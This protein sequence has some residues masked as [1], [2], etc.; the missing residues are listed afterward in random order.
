MLRITNINLKEGIRIRLPESWH[1]VLS[2]FCKDK[3]L[4]YEYEIERITR[5]RNDKEICCICK[6]KRQNSRMYKRIVLKEFAVKYLL[7]EELTDSNIGLS[8][9]KYLPAEN[10]K[11]LIT[12]ETNPSKVVPG[13]FKIDAMLISVYKT[14]IVGLNFIIDFINGDGFTSVSYYCTG[15]NKGTWKLL[16]HPDDSYMTDYEKMFQ[17]T[18]IHK[19]YVL[20]SCEKL[21]KYLEN[22]GIVNHA[23]LLR[24]RAI[25]HDNSKITCEDELHALSSIINDKESMK[26]SSKQLSAIKQDAIKLHWKH[27]THHPEHF[28]NCA[29][30]TRLDVMEM[31]CDWHARSTQYG[32]DLLKFV[33][34]RQDDRFH[35]PEWMF[36][37]IWHYCEVLV[38]K[39]L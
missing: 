12:N 10:S 3:S 16:E 32:T 34:D 20:R 24:E 11:V 18:F 31:C 21:A 6:A 9:K 1:D 5:D 13:I 27:N 15:E 35:F 26:D 30:M 14:S 4:P 2:V 36:A 37:E 19:D 33:K 39:N 17:D 22:Q 23:R 7:A 28:K 29:D 25:V 8:F 38:D